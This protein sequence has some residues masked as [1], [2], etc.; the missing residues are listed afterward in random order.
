MKH[1]LMSWRNMVEENENK[2]DD[3]LSI[4]ENEEEKTSIDIEK[5]KSDRYKLENEKLKDENSQRRT[6]VIWMMFVVSIWLFITALIVFVQ[7]CKGSL[8]STVLCTL[9]STTTVNVLG[10]AVI[11]LRGLF[12]KK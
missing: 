1:C 10:L 7:L 4:T 12:N 9:L 2:I 3:V 5:V 6:L 8:S 11:V